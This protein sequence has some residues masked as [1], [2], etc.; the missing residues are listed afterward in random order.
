MRLDVVQLIDR[1]RLNS[2]SYIWFLPLKFRRYLQ[3]AQ[4]FIPCPGTLFSL[5]SFRDFVGPDRLPS[6]DVNPHAVY[7]ACRM[8]VC[9]TKEPIGDITQ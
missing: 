6:R 7:G 5:V 4:F 8:A 3:R 1:I 9:V 2:Q